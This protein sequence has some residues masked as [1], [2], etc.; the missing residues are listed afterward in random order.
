MLQSE[1]EI[2]LI[3]QQYADLCNSVAVAN[4]R[5][6]ELVK[7][8]VD[9]TLEFQAA[10]A[11]LTHALRKTREMQ[12]D[13]RICGESLLHVC[14][15]IERLY[16]EEE[17][18]HIQIKHG[19]E[20]ACVITD[21]VA[22][23]GDIAQFEVRG[24]NIEWQAWVCDEFKF[25]YS[26]YLTEWHLF[27][28]AFVKWEIFDLRAYVQ[29]LTRNIYPSEIQKIVLSYVSYS[30]I[31]MLNLFYR[32]LDDFARTDGPNRHTLWSLIDAIRERKD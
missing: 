26:I 17:K 18:Y 14:F 27:W 13:A 4:Y 30:L 16:Y 12:H 31:E 24:N 11:K 10:H 15:N 20:P 8:C 23:I 3:K 29:K 21:Y 1:E 25:D 5:L 7:R 22:E 28:P 19:L 6:S 32:Y 9:D 2:M